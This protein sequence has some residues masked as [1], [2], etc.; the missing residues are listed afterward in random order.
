VGGRRS[1]CALLLLRED[2]LIVSNEW[3]G[4]I[5][6]VMHV[7]IVCVAPLLVKLSDE[8]VSNRDLGLM[9]VQCV[10]VQAESFFF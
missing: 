1:V 8:F 7:V 10:M 2:L 3:K 5:E 4:R 6:I 9:T